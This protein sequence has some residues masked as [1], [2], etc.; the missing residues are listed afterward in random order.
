MKTPIYETTSG[1][2]AALL[3][4]RSFVFGDLYTI[5]LPNNN[6]TLRLCSGDVDWSYSGNT[7]GHGGPL[8]D[9][10]G[11]RPTAHWKLGLDVD[12]WQFAIIPRAVDPMTGAAWPDLIGSVPWLQAIAAGALMGATVQVDRAYLPS[13]PAFPRA[14]AI[15]PTGVV[16]IF[17]GRVASVDLERTIAHV[18]LN[19]HLDILSADMPRNL[20]QAGCR[21]TLFDPRCALAA[22]SYGV[23][24]TA[25]GASSQSSPVAAVGAPGGSGTYAL[26]R[27]VFTSGKNA[28]FTRSIRTASTVSGVTTFTLIAPMPFPVLPGDTFTAYPGCD[29]K[30]VTCGT[31][32]NQ[33]NFGGQDQIPA[34]ETAV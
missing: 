15:V 2:L 6:G 21:H 27:V 25:T 26:G 4:S 34:P 1:A 20:F 24:C 31:W 11:S 30:Y 14:P 23:S 13:W 7:W 33:A 16:N 9:T 3:A 12:S 32:G 17:T 28:T 10:P 18:T 29:K 8:I 22:S 5:S 19:S